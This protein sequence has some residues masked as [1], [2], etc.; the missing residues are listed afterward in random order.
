MT[1][2]IHIWE[3][4]LEHK[5]YLM[6]LDKS[7][8]KIKCKVLI[9]KMTQRRSQRLRKMN[10]NKQLRAINNQVKKIKNKL[11]IKMKYRILKLRWITNQSITSPKMKIRMRKNIRTG[12]KTSLRQMMINLMIHLKMN[13]SRIL[14][15][16]MNWKLSLA[17]I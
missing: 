16:R 7:Y 1:N 8:K 11:I 3:P 4:K 10:S 6:S 9:I 12:L 15:Y 13:L 5:L 14:V 2:L 17:A